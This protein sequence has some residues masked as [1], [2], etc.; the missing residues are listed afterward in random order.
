MFNPDRIFFCCCL[1]ML[2]TTFCLAQENSSTLKKNPFSQPESLK[3]QPTVT[4]PPPPPVQAQPAL[5]SEF[6]LTATLISVNGP[7]AVVN[8]ELLMMGEEVK[9][10][11]LILVDDS[12]AV[13][14]YQGK[15]YDI[16]LDD[17]NNQP[18]TKQ[19]LR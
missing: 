19:R 16:S 3:L 2:Q 5:F 6:I 9:G 7:M 14:R 15:L 13:I 10:M 17:N 18:S 1:L 11:R 8:G 4:A 12:R